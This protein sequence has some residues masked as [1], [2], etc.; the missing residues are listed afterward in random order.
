MWVSTKLFEALILGKGEAEGRAAELTRINIALQ[1]TI[2]WL[3]VRL[4]QSE[5]ERAAL[6]A[7]YMGVKIPS[8]SIE[9]ERPSNGV[10]H[11]LNDAMA[12]FKD[13]GDDEAKRLGIDW[14]DN[15][16]IR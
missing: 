11:A 5:H 4:T 9:Q 8:F 10:N 15:G 3:G 13:V 12:I 1:G 2:D 7:N 6:T 16:T 14:D